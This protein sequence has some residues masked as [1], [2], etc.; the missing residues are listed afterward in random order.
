MIWLVILWGLLAAILESYNDR[1][2][3]TKK[4]KIADGVY[5][6]IAT[7]CLCLLVW[8]L[9][10]TNPLKVIPLVLAVRVLVFDYLVTYLLIR[11]GV[12]VGN[13]F[14]YTGKTSKWD[15]LISRVNPFVRLGLGVAVFALSLWWFL[16]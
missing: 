15:K 2:G 4:D 3:E 13:W 7:S 1:L 11:N 16:S 14:S 9:D 6:A 10:R 12:I 8:I 5:L